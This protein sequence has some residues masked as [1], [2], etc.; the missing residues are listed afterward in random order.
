VTHSVVVV[1]GGVAAAAAAFDLAQSGRD[2]LRIEVITGPSLGGAL[3]STDLG[4]H[5]I[6]LGA[7][8]FLA[9]RSEARD[10]IRDVGLA[11]DLVDIAAAG[12]WVYLN[13]ELVPLPTGTVLG[14]PTQLSQVRSMSGLS[15]A[16]RRE[17]W[18]DWYRPRRLTLP[19][20]D[21]AIGDIVRGKFGPHLTRELIEPMLGGIHAGRVDDLGAATVFPQLLAAARS[22]GSLMRAVAPSTAP[23]PS[24]PAFQSL[25]GSLGSLVP[26]VFGLL[27]ER[28]VII[29]RDAVVTK[30][31]R[32]PGAARRLEV[33]TRSTT[34]PADG[35]ILAVGPRPL[36]QIAGHIDARV[37]ALAAVPSASV[38]MVTYR[39]ARRDINLP[40]TGTGVLVPLGTTRDG[41]TDS[42][43]TTA[44]TL[45]DRKWSH[46]HDDDWALVRVHCG[47]IDDARISQFTDAQLAARIDEEMSQ[48]VGRWA[49]GHCVA[50]QRW[51]DAL[52]QYR[53]GHGDLVAAARASLEPDH[54][55]LT[56]LLCDGVGIPATIGS[57][58]RAAATCLAALG[59]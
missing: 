41:A 47:R 54:I 7:D 42:L 48:I 49:G 34:T 19:D 55:F 20:G 8:G 50:V 29:R 15:R 53:V 38:A 18:R 44:I 40:A 26:H 23:G 2:D 21:V 30:V 17:A 32:T 5:R 10:F 33:D 28:G 16:A 35:V 13:R 56:G 37:A 9:K 46:L 6:D 14:V 1:G 39:V 36:G 59:A 31:R 52:P 51:T 4:G 11:D 22:G 58:R 45:L 25:R 27:A 24:G 43:L 57:A 3:Q 12:A